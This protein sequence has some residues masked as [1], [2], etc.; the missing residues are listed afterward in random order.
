[1]ET[2]LATSLLVVLLGLMLW[3]YSSSLDTREDGMQRSTDVQLARVII[4]RMAEELRQASGNTPG[5]GPG[6]IGYE[7]S[8]SVNTLV[9]PDKILAKRR[10]V[11]EDQVAGQFDLQEVR[12]YVAWDEENLD[13]NGQARCLGLV[14]RVTKTFN[15]GVVL[16][17]DAAVEE[18]EV[19][20]EALAVKEELYA[21]QIKY[22]DMR[23]FDGAMW[24]PTWELQG[25][26]TLPSIV[27]VTI[28]FSPDHAQLEEDLELV[29]ENFLREDELADPLAPD[30]FTMFV[31]LVQAEANPI[32]VRLQR[33]ASAMSESEGGM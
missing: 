14:R 21:P 12:Y 13:E 20:A 23:Y 9:L 6:L 30:K 16:E 18:G 19:D 31:R 29:D 27:R 32:G 1:L 2:I 15:R 10:G 17:D 22:L 11:S 28:G 5:Y 3:F 33:T 24:W 7:Y 4:G 8:Y 26:N 25:G